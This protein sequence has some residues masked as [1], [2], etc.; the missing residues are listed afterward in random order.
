MDA[1]CIVTCYG[2][3]PYGFR[4]VFNSMTTVVK[5]IVPKREKCL[6]RKEGDCVKLDFEKAAQW[7]YEDEMD[8]S[9]VFSWNQNCGY[10]WYSA[11]KDERYIYLFSHK[12]GIEQAVKDGFLEKEGKD[13]MCR[14]VDSMNSNIRMASDIF[15]FCENGERTRRK[16]FVNNCFDDF[17]KCVSYNVHITDL[18][19]VESLLEVVSRQMNYDDL[20]GIYNAERFEQEVKTLLAQDMDT[21]Y[22]IIRLDFDQFKIINDVLG[23]DE[24]DKVLRYVGNVLKEMRTECRDFCYCRIIAD[25]FAICMSYRELKEIISLVQK[26]DGRIGEYPVKCRLTP[27]YGIYRITDRT[28]PVSIMLDYAKLACRSVKGNII[29]NFAFYI[30]E[31]REQV[32][33]EMEI[34]RDMENAL[35][36]QQF[37]LY[38]QPKYDISTGEL[39]GAEALCRWQH[40]VKGL[41][42]PDSFIPLFE[43]NGFIVKLD[44][45]MWEETCRTIRKWLDEGR[46]VHPISLN[47]SRIHAYNN[48]FETDILNLVEKYDIPS[49]LL[50]LELTES[51]YLDQE[52]GLYHAMNRLKKKGLLFSVDDFGTG[53]SSLNMLKS[54]PVDIVKLDR[55][56]LNETTSSAKGRTII[57]NMITMA[58]ELNIRVIAEGVESVEQAALLLEMGC[59]LA[60]GYYYSRPLSIDDFEQRAFWNDSR[61]QLGQQIRF[62]LGEQEKFLEEIKF[63]QGSEEVLLPENQG[64]VMAGLHGLRKSLVSRIRKYRKILLG[65]SDI[66]YEFNLVQGDS[67]VYIN[68]AGNMESKFLVGAYENF[69]QKVMENVDDRYMEYVQNE[70][71]IDT[72]REKYRAGEDMVNICY[73]VENVVDK[74][75]VYTKNVFILLGDEEGNLQEV[76][77]SIQKIR[78]ENEVLQ[79]IR[80]WE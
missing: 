35:L 8:N 20:T 55:G 69:Y 40:P 10:Y 59:D 67:V 16:I 14:L 60:Q 32:V 50:E 52:E 22:A 47:V 65:I 15:V 5:T 36:Q 37:K 9:F 73:R 56:F 64:Q 23:P 70:I 6:G 30:E 46:T 29:N 51:A 43:K 45:Y 25:V 24:G 39:I 13:A 76:F 31:L 3:L 78:E 58:N 66:I 34:E 11:L 17:G 53:Y 48:S 19:K 62:V 21:D 63:L 26:L 7:F 61:V 2:A 77:L 80:S 75:N 49:N 27:N 54:I 68:S 72:L 18:G 38:L 4:S 71:H 79:V 57:R 74:R 28:I 44:R 42:P 1:I 12:D 41:I 33:A